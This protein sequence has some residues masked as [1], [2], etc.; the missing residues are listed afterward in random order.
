MRQAAWTTGK[1]RRGVAGLGQK[2]KAES[3]GFT[4]RSFSGSGVPHAGPTCLQVCSGLSQAGW[5]GSHARG[6]RKTPIITVSLLRQVSLVAG[7]GWAWSGRGQ[8]ENPLAVRSHIGH[9][10]D[11]GGGDPVVALKGGSRRVNRVGFRPGGRASGMHLGL[12]RR[13]HGGTWQVQP[14]APPPARRAS[15]ALPPP[16]TSLC[17]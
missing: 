3:Q 10:G 2:L 17:G 1:G 13:P 11:L 5:R 4:W 6:A 9:S 16:H 7:V 8:R 15:P 14:S 12:A